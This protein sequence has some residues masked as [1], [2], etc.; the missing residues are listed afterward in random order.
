MNSTLLSTKASWAPQRFYWWPS[1]KTWHMDI[2]SITLPWLGPIVEETLT[3][4][5]YVSLFPISILNIYMKFE[6]LR[7][8]QRN[9]WENKAK[10]CKQRKLCKWRD[11]MHYFFIILQ[12]TTSIVIVYSPQY[13]SMQIILN[14]RETDSS[15]IY[16][17]QFIW[18]HFQ[19]H[20]CMVQRL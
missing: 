16:S 10:I 15:F 6:E 14:G 8:N 18:Q 20:A 19:F 9:F 4:G 7:D 17:S 11:Q 1:A 5:E 12:V 3:S 2:R 13:T